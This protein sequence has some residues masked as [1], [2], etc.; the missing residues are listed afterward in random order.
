MYIRTKR[1]DKAGKYKY[2]RKYHRYKSQ[3]A[4]NGATEIEEIANT[5][6]ISILIVSV[7]MCVS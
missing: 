3:C 7:P 1:A 6:A 2:A 4:G 5:A